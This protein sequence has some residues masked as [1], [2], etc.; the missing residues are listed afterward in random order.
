VFKGQQLS[1]IQYI[2]V[3]LA[4]RCQIIPATNQQSSVT[5][6]ATF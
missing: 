1:T 6:K 3:S 4:P 5:C 2:S